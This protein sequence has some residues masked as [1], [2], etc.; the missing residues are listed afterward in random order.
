M[1]L[2]RPAHVTARYS[3]GVTELFAPVVIGVSLQVHIMQESK[4]LGWA[5]KITEGD[6]E[7]TIV[8]HLEHFRNKDG[9]GSLV[10][11]KELAAH[12]CMCAHEGMLLGLQIL[13]QLSY[14]C[15]IIC[16]L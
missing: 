5:N 6:A 7:E 10:H 14:S 11:A 15:K 1:P 16:H 13:Q 8:G 9:Q 3:Y 2:W 4:L 12:L